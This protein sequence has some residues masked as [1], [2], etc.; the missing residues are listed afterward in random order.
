MENTDSLMG[1]CSHQ[2]GGGGAPAEAAVSALPSAVRTWGW[3]DTLD[4]AAAFRIRAAWGHVADNV[5]RSRVHH[6]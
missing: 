3:I 1:G 5:S 6:R 2:E 4:C